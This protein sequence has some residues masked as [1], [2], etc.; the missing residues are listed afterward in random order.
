MNMYCRCSFSGG[1]AGRAGGGGR[2][3]L[4]PLEIYFK[5]CKQKAKLKVNNEGDCKCLSHEFIA[6]LIIV[7]VQ[8]LFYLS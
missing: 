1:G 5:C 8:F 7:L 4:P 6:V 3:T 2:G